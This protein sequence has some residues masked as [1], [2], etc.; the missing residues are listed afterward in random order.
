[1]KAK[2]R[3]WRAEGLCYS[4]GAAA[5]EGHKLCAEHLRYH[6]RRRK[7]VYAER[8][9]AGLC[10][11]C[12][13][14]SSTSLCRPCGDANLASQKRMRDRK[15]KERARSVRKTRSRHERGLCVCCPAPVEPGRWRC[16]AC[17]ARNRETD[18]ELRLERKEAGLCQ[19]GAEPRP[20]MGFCER[21]ATAA[22]RRKAAYRKRKAASG[23]CLMGGCEKT[24]KTK[25]YCAEHAAY[26][27]KAVSRWQRRQTAL[28]RAQIARV[29]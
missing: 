5:E 12:G 23:L 18:R 22:T 16:A 14:P 29:A 27:T 28:R 15:K 13:A 21:C 25:T 26:H 9:A 6:R 20:G 11:Q 2:E 19:C 17:L 7:R 3:E 24:L 8:R 1:M 10:F 4:C